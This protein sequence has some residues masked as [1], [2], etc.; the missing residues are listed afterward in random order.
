MLAPLVFAYAYW[1]RATLRVEKRCAAYILVAFSIPIAVALTEELVLR[2][3][4]VPSP[5]VTTGGMV[6]SNLLIAHAVMVRGLLVFT[7]ERATAHILDALREALVLISSDGTVFYANKASE[8]MLLYERGGLRGV[9]SHDIIVRDATI[10]TSVFRIGFNDSEGLLRRRDGETIPVSLTT[11]P[12]R[13][14]EGD[15]LGTVCA[16]VDIRERKRAERERESYLRKLMQADRLASLGI[17]AAGMAHEVNNPN[18]LIRLSADLLA[19]V[20]QDVV[21]TLDQYQ[22]HVP[23]FSLGGVPY[24]SMRPRLAELS[25]SIVSS[26]ERIDSIVHGLKHFARTDE[27]DMSGEVDVKVLIRSAYELVRYHV[28]KSTKRFT[29]RCPDDIPP[30]CGN[31]QRLEQVVVNL[32]INAAQALENDEQSI[33]LSVLHE[34]RDE[35]VVIQVRDEGKGICGEHLGKVCD[36]FFTTRRNEGGTGLGLS[37]CYSIV[38]E[39]AGTLDVQSRAGQGTTVSVRLPA[40]PYPHDGS[41][42]G[43]DEHALS[44]TDTAC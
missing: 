14:K 1:R 16:A 21:K 15:L 38:E 44:G 9:N 12:V 19:D 10:D 37:I 33:A 26:S 3:L 30:V 24:A 8:D 34:K 31:H 35:Q 2:V 17:L 28:E 39:H 41:F 27:N 20:N 7:P 40:V 6:A 32:L 42:S 13:T 29:I 4:S 11:T 5:K 22:K 25:A 18:A 43:N 23:E 36:P